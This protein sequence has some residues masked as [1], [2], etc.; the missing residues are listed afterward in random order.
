VQG[1][2]VTTNFNINLVNSFVWMISRWSQEN[3]FGY[4]RKEFNIGRLI[5]HELED[6]SDSVKLINP[7]YRKEHSMVRKYSAK[8][9]RSRKIFGAMTLDEDIGSDPST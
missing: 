6:M 3:F 2:M 8:L 5:D 1:S 7:K 4:M 9:D